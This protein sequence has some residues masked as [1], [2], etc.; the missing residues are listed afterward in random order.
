MQGSRTTRRRRRRIEAAAL[1]AA[2]AAVSPAFAAGGPLGIDHRLGEDGATGIWSRRNQNVLQGVTPLVVI[3]GA[4]WEGDDTRYGHTSWQAVDSLVIGAVTTVG[5]KL[6]FGRARPSQTD[7]PNRWFQGSG[8]NSFPS[9]EVMEITTAVTPFILEYGADH[10]AVW[11]LELLP[12]Y[13]AVARVKSRAHWQSDVLASF[14]IGTAIGYYTHSRPTALSVGLLP[15]G[16]T[17]GW[18]KSF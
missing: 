12:A 9:G 11:A 4:L 16:L 14:A 15:R 10:P 8:H 3:A 5:M 18:K 2:A 17:V 1:V 13:D 7:D 6:A